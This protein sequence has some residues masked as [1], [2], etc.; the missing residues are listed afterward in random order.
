MI[1][2]KL[3]LRTWHLIVTQFIPMDSVTRN[4]MKDYMGQI[5]TLGVTLYLQEPPGHTHGK[6]QVGFTYCQSIADS[7]LNS[8][9]FTERAGPGPLDPPSV[10]W[11]YHSDVSG[12]Q[13]IYSGL[14]GALLVYKPGELR[15]HTLDVPAPKSSSL[16]EEVLTL[17][18][19]VDENRSFYIDQ[20]TLNRTNITVGELQ[21][22]RLDPAFQESNL[23]HSINGRIFGN[24]NGLNLTVGHQ[25]RW[26]V[27]SI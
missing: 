27:V 18:I 17:F 11:T 4:P 21:A 6:S 7:I 9:Y 8:R 20:N 23:K 26:H 22:N 14:V 1:H 10:S 13:D 15:R 5:R 19:I 12:A 16:T 2:S 24:L 3:C 25:A